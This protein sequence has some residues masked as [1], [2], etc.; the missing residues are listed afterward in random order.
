MAS[1]RAKISVLQIRQRPGEIKDYT[2]PLLFDKCLPYSA[3]SVIGTSA[4]LDVFASIFNFVTDIFAGIPD[5]IGRI[6][7]IFSQLFRGTIIF[8]ACKQRASQYQG[9]NQPACVE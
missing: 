1:V 2:W 7:N 9:K 4:F 8:A 5:F 3:V 6:V